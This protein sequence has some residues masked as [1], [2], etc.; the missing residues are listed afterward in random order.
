MY[1]YIFTKTCESL[2]IQRH[3]IKFWFWPWWRD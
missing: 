2:T 3:G 1:T